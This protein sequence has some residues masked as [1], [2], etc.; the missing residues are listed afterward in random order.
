MRSIVPP[1]LKRVLKGHHSLQVSPM[2]S[3]LGTHIRV[4][5]LYKKFLWHPNPPYSNTTLS[6]VY[7]THVG[8]VGEDVS[9]CSCVLAHL[10]SYIRI[11][12]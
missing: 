3:K 6:L 10:C 7:D 1:F 5:E 9:S 2:D 4:N 11:F 8:Q 12:F